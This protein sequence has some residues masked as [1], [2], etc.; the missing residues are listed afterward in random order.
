VVLTSSRPVEHCSLSPAIAI[1]LVFH[2][3]DTLNL[4]SQSGKARADVASDAL[5]NLIAFSRR[6]WSPFLESVDGKP[7]E[8]GLRWKRL[9]EAQK[10]SAMNSNW[11]CRY[12][13]KLALDQQKFA[14]AHLRRFFELPHS[15]QHAPELKQRY[16]QFWA[17]FFGGGRKRARG[18]QLL[19]RLRLQ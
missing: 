16:R 2:P 13:W 4:F 15:C 18:N 3:H 17:E 8:S 9:A 14:V 6:L 10:K 11:S 7:F 19:F 12:P 1:L 5:A